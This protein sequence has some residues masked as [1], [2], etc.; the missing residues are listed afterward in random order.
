MQ[1]RRTKLEQNLT[2]RLDDKIPASTMTYR[3][4]IELA[5]ADG[6]G[7]RFKLTN[8]LNT[9]KNGMVYGNERKAYW[10]EWNASYVKQHGLKSTN[11]QE[12]YIA[13]QK[14]SS[15]YAKAVYKSLVTLI[16]SQIIRDSD[17]FREELFRNCT[18]AF[19]D[20]LWCFI[21]GSLLMMSRPA[22]AVMD[23]AR[24]IKQSDIALGTFF[25]AKFNRCG[26]EAVK[27]WIKKTA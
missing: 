20:Y 26:G 6:R 14:A 8:E 27:Q 23:I 22:M 3:E 5:V 16:A 7:S 21:G 13:A 10:T 4:R 9:V 11:S 1:D 25:E 19:R 15:V 24:E 17:K 18:I 12:R 2:V